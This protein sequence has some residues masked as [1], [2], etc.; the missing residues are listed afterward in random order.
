MLVDTGATHSTH[1]GPLRQHLS[2]YSILWDFTT[3]AIHKAFELRS[4]D[5]CWPIFSFM[6]LTH[7]YICLAG[8]CCVNWKWVYWTRSWPDEVEVVFPDGHRVNCLCTSTTSGTQWLLCDERWPVIPMMDIY[9]A[10]LHPKDPKKTG[11]VTHHSALY[12]IIKKVMT[13]T[14]NF[15][16]WMG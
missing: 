16:K 9:W 2:L 10:L 12:F 1:M 5:R 4:E 13:F 6:P 7:L 14:N 11:V 3:P 15:P 8:T